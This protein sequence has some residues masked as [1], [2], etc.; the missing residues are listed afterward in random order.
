[1][2]LNHFFGSVCSGLLAV[3]IGFSGVSANPL[4]KFEISAQLSE[5]QQ[6]RLQAWREA[7]KIAD[8]ALNQ[9]TLAEQNARLQV[10]RLQLELTNVQQALALAQQDAQ[11]RKQSLSALSQQAVE[12]AGKAQH[13]QELEK[14][15]QQLQAQQQAVQTLQT[16]L[17]ERQ[18]NLQQAQQEARVA[19]LWLQQ[20]EQLEQHLQQQS[21]Q[22]KAAAEQQKQSQRVEQLR[23]ELSQL[24]DSMSDL[25]KRSWL[26]AEI[27]VATENAQLLLQDTRFN[28]LSR[29]LQQLQDTSA[30]PHIDTLHQQVTDI[31]TLR[32]QLHALQDLLQHKLGGIKRQLAVLNKQLEAPN[33]HR[34]THNYLSK[35]EK[36]LTQLQQALEQQQAQLLPLYIEA[37]LLDTD[38]QA[39][40]TVATRQ[41]LLQRRQLPSSLTAWEMLWQEIQSIPQVFTQSAQQAW[42]HGQHQWQQSQSRW[43][44][45]TLALLWL[46]LLAWQQRRMQRRLV[47]LQQQNPDTHSFSVNSLRVTLALALRYLP[48]FALSGLLALSILLLPLQHILF[49]LLLGLLGFWLVLQMSRRLAWRLLVSD[50]APKAYRDSSFYRQLSRLLWLTWIFTSLALLIHFLP[51]SRPLTELYDSFYLLFLG[52]L[53]LPLLH[54]RRLS[55]DAL[56]EKLNHYWLFV[57]KISTLLFVLGGIAM[58]VLALFGYINLAWA[59]GRFLGGFLLLLTLWLVARGY[60]KDVIVLVKNY[61]LQHSPNYGLLWTQDIIPL[62]HKLLQIALVLG[63][64]W[65]LLRIN[66]LH[67]AS[68]SVQAGFDY[69]L[70]NLSTSSITLGGLTLSLFAFWFVIWFGQWIRQITYRWI[71]VSI[72]DLG[73][74]HSLSAFTQYL[75]VTIG[76]LIALNIMGVDL[77]TLTV[78]AGALG[79]GLGFGL[80]NVADNFI[81]GLL[82]LIE[83][84]LRAGDVINIDGKYEGKVK[85]IGIRSLTISTWDNQ[86]VII[87]N[88]QLISTPF[89]NWSHDDW[90]LRTVLYIGVSYDSDLKQVNALLRNILDDYPIILKDPESNIFLN[91]FADS[92]VVFRV[93]YFIDADKNSLL[94]TKSS[95][96][97]KIWD[98]FKENNIEI[99]YP[100]RDL[101]V[102][103]AL[104][105][106]IVHDKK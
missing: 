46:L 29:D 87:P 55:I 86:D 97:M 52:V 48:E 89:V 98:T 2:P 96:L 99:P 81:S 94:S 36:L 104:P 25:A 101:H 9:A 80:K 6:A 77:T 83:R 41:N 91:E 16:S 35:A 78:F 54:L 102:K 20:V 47:Q 88:S 26:E 72:I 1:M 59:F 92:A 79:V 84:P 85:Q 27:L 42:Q 37:E 53:I 69:P 76:I 18:Q 68:D 70:L 44:L 43:W 100:Q 74:R 45:A 32:Q 50:E 17:Q 8:T 106:A 56:A 75:L 22:Q 90:I 23:Q 93:Q 28:Q 63:L 14:Q 24:S 3:F 7:G 60:L 31:R 11:A 13:Q 66:G 82:L 105:P 33:I 95:L 38:L 34:Q 12:E 73:V 61:A 10:E 4:T 65:L 51:F 103:T 5:A 49:G 39:R 62:L 19:T 57:I 58:S 40:L 15:S 30:E 21:E 67:I 71:Y 64:G